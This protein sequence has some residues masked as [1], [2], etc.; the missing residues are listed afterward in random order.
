VKNIDVEKKKITILNQ[1]QQSNIIETLEFLA[2][3]KE[4]FLFV[5]IEKK[6]NIK[7][8]KR[9]RARSK[10]ERMCMQMIDLKLD[11]DRIDCS[12]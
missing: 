5:S 6:Y 11:V 3:S 9:R 7:A 4:Q 10:R 1:F 2:S 12:V 8:I